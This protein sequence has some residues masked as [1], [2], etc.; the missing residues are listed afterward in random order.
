MNRVKQLNTIPN[1]NQQLITLSPS[2]LSYDFGLGIGSIKKVVQSI[3]NDNDQLQIN[4]SIALTNEQYRLIGHL[5]I[6]LRLIGEEEERTH[7]KTNVTE[8]INFKS[9]K[10]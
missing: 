6:M 5:D 4:E 8:R 1:I 2:E 10:L 7:Y 3:T 9:T